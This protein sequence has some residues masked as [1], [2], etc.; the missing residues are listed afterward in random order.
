M[1]GMDGIALVHVEAHHFRA[2][3]KKLQ[4]LATVSGVTNVRPICRLYSGPGG[5]YPEFHVAVFV[6]GADTT[7]LRE[8]FGAL[9]AVGCHIDGY[10]G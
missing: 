7:G 5:G 1:D 8:I 4:T 3:R 6:H 9:E 2:F 10:G